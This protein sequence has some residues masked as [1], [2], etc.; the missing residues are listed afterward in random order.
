MQNIFY[1]YYIKLLH[2]FWAQ[3]WWGR[4]ESQAA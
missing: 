1:I 4:G 2:M 3:A